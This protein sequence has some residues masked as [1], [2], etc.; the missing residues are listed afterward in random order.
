[1]PAGRVGPIVDPPHA[2][3][4]CHHGVVRRLI[5]LGLALLAAGCGS[6]AVPAAA[7]V[8]TIR[9]LVAGTV[10]LAGPALMVAAADPES[11]F[12]EVRLAARQ[13]DLAV[14]LTAPGRAEPML[15]AAGFDA[16]VCPRPRFLATAAAGAEVGLRCAGSFGLSYAVSLSGPT[17]VVRNGSPFLYPPSAGV[18]AIDRGGP[19]AVI[20]SRGID[21]RARLLVS[22]LGALLSGDPDDGALLE[23]LLEHDGIIAY[24]IGRT[25]HTDFRVRFAG[26]DLPVGDA[27]LLD[28]EWWALTGPVTPAPVVRPPAIPAFAHGDLVAASLG[29]VTGDGQPDLAA[30]YRHPFR[31]S[32]LSEAYAGAVGVDAAGRSAHLGVFTPGGEALWAAGYIPRPVGD[33]A[34]CDGA[35]AL[36][37]AGLDDPAVVSTGAAAWQGFSL[38][39][40][41]ELPGPGV[42]GCAD[43]DDDGKLD[44][45]IL[46][47]AG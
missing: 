30:S 42:P 7:P 27:V 32:A 23:V 47:R 26:W 38:R 6:A 28:G 33:L 21:G 35:V 46:G 10:D 45:L 5:L 34:A 13:S 12:R 43:V 22:G 18:A 17:L 14:V 1:M 40:A 41:P 24:R 37:Y 25:S 20:V 36:A 9:L 3:G 44:P 16:V 4:P 15:G 8:G 2:A 39:P 19:A 29:D 11:L 31:P